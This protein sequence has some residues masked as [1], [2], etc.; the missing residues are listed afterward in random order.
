MLQEGI[1]NSAVIHQGIA[2]GND[3]KLSQLGTEN[4]ADISQHQGGKLSG[5][6]SAERAVQNGEGNELNLSMGNFNRAGV[7]QDGDFNT[8]D[9]RQ[10]GFSADNVQLLQE[11]NDNEVLLA[12]SGGTADIQQIGLGENILNGLAGLGS[13]ANQSGG[14]SMSVVQDGFDNTLFI[15]QDGAHSAAVDQMGDSNTATVSQSN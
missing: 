1:T 14:A 10:N 3:I 5:Y 7:T 6:G 8:A 9:V 12:Q 2:R 11:G 4:I 13:T 15:G